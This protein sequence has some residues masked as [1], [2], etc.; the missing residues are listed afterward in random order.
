VQGAP[1]LTPADLSIL[2]LASGI[3]PRAAEWPGAASCSAF[4]EILD[5]LHVGLPRLAASDLDTGACGAQTA[6]RSGEFLPPLP[7]AAAALPVESAGDTRIGQAAPTAA[8]SRAPPEMPESGESGESSP[9]LREPAQTA[10]TINPELLIALFGRTPAG[11]A[12]PGPQSS[13]PS[14]DVIAAVPVMA[15]SL[16]ATGAEG[17]GRGRGV[18]RAEWLRQRV[19]AATPGANRPSADVPDHACEPVSREAAAGTARLEPAPV[20]GALSAVAPAGQAV[21]P[22][23]SPDPAGVVAALSDAQAHVTHGKNALH[24]PATEHLTER[25]GS[26]RWAQQFASRVQWFVSEGVSNARLTL[27]PPDLGPIDVRIAVQPDQVS[28][29]SIQFIV[30]HAAVRDAV[31]DA[32]PKLREMLAQSDIA[33]GDAQVSTELSRQ[34][35][36]GQG[37]FT[38][39]PSEWFWTA[40]EDLMVEPDLTPARTIIGHGLI[41][42]FI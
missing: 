8:F 38:P 28:Q 27:N 15:E 33:L 11:S 22:D 23:P 10:G 26:H 9:D 7:R 30:Q 21:S 5:R 18:S 13:E 35:A 39:D 2:P 20:P 24:P 6:M 17:E 32:L 19:A 40:A 37:R 12:E 4:G 14:K 29:T 34:H 41:D 42:T 31:E 1:T 25:L 16:R 3:P 36:D